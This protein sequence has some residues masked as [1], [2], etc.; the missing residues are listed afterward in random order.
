MTRGGNAA[1]PSQP[2]G[3]KLSNFTSRLFPFNPPT[4]HT[5]KRWRVQLWNKQDSF[6]NMQLA[7]AKDRPWCHWVGTSPRCTQA[8]W[9]GC[10][11]RCEKISGTVWIYYGFQLVQLVCNIS[12]FLFYISNSCSSVINWDSE[13]FPFLAIYATLTHRLKAN[14]ICKAVNHSID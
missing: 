9:E 8:A 5:I 3:A 1:H 11:V 14:L 2:V 12:D 13:N 6:K 7:V 4:K 10:S